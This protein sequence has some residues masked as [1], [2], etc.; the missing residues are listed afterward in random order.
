MSRSTDNQN[1]WETVKAILRGKLT[2]LNPYIREERSKITNLSSHF[3]REKKKN[4]LNPKEAE[5]KK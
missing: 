5:K 1:L 2:A 4:K 3:R